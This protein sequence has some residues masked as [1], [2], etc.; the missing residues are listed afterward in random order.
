MPSTTACPVATLSSRRGTR[1]VP[2]SFGHERYGRCQAAVKPSGNRS[3]LA[4]RRRANDERGSDASRT[5]RTNDGDD[6]LDHHPHDGTGHERARLRRARGA[7]RHHQPAQ[8]HHPGGLPP[9]DRALRHLVRVRR[10]GRGRGGLDRSP[11]GRPDQ[12]REGR[13]VDPA[14]VGRGGH[15][16][17][18]G[19]GDRGLRSGRQP[20]SAGAA[21]SA[22]R[23]PRHHRPEGRRRGGRS[24]GEGPWVL[25]SARCSR[26]P[27]VLR[28]TEPDLHGGPVQRRT[29]GRARGADRRRHPDPCGDPDAEP[30]GPAPHPRARS[31]G[32]RAHPGRRVPVDGCA[33]L[34]A[35]A[36]R[37]SERRSGPAWPDPGSERAGIAVAAARPPIGRSDAVAAAIRICGSPTSASTRRPAGSRTTWRST[38]AGTGN[39]IRWRRDSRAG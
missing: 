22:D 3:G 28:R 37:A 24:L 5:D 23:R 20:V 30:L 10:R 21:R 34:H 13:R 6:R 17:P 27:G 29:R 11:P 35:A 15:A 26:G 32:G 36:G 14:A 25:P 1:C 9:R 31:A 39:P 4:G 19:A 33:A 12:G 2:R 8:D 18:A 38:P 7:E 16:S